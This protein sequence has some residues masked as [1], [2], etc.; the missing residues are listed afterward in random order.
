MFVDFL[1]QPARTGTI[2]QGSASMRELVYECFSLDQG[3]SLQETHFSFEAGTSPQKA[4]Q[5]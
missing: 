3:Y 1:L 4:V 2:T 5:L